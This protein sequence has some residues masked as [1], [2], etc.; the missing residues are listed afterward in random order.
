[1]YSAVEK[2]TR[3]PESKKLTLASNVL[4]AIDFAAE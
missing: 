1:V 4:L 2:T 3:H